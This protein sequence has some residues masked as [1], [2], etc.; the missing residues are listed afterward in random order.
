M[1][2]PITYRLF[3][4]YTVYLLVRFIEKAFTAVPERAAL[5][6]GRLVGRIV[7]V[8]FPDRKEAAIENLTIAFGNE[9]SER[10]IRRTA[11]KSFEHVGLLAVEFLRIRHW[12]E[13]EMRR[14][15]IIEGRAPFNLSMMPGNHGICLLN[16]HF[17]CFEVSAATIKHL[18]VKLHVIVTGLKNPFLNRYLFSRAGAGTGISTL[19]HKGIVQKSLD[20]LEEGEMVAFLAD[21]RGD[22]ERGCFVDF[23]GTK[24]PANEVFARLA[25]D[26]NAR[27]MPLCTYR[28]DDGRYCSVFGEPVTFEPTGDRQGDLQALSQAFHNVFEEWLRFKPEQGYWL[29]RK[30]RRK[31][32]KRKRPKKRPNPSVPTETVPEI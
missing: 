4:D 18:G 20:L 15:I 8:L 6:F 24:A 14:K 7:Y 23:F 27:I 28:T 3:L 5:A 31:P 25:I 16:S 32:S 1:A 9:R 17:G 2:R 10:W 30:W 19:P 21:Q 11:R 29:Q 22:A 26:G 12:S 13:E